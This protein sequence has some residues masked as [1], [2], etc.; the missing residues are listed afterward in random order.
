[1]NKKKDVSPVVPQR[2]KFKETLTIQPFEWTEKQKQFISLVT[3][4]NTKIVFL[5]GPA[6]TSKTYLS[7]Y[8]GLVFLAEKRVS[9]LIYI[10]T[11]I[12]SAS[13]GLG[14][15]PG[16]SEDKFAPFMMPLED[17]LH[18][19]LNGGDVQ[20]LK[21][22]NRVQ[23]IPINYLRGA[24]LNAKFILADESQNFDF[25]ELTT[26]ITRFG[27]FS[28][29]IVCGDTRQSDING[30][31]GFKDMYNLFNDEESRN[32]GIHCFEFTKED[33]VRSEEVKFILG[34]LDQHNELLLK[35][36]HSTS[37]EKIQ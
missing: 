24:N 36:K 1:M 32:N 2:N 13:K 15:L 9:D 25:K 26:L 6:G 17:K 16:E 10:R 28:K 23:A 11:V 8:L 37:T 4:K 21:N 5:N 20:K 12:E 14:Y 3:N 35:S 31:S 33:V 34:K 30:K 19:L 18:E 22:D 27:R 7:V 29:M